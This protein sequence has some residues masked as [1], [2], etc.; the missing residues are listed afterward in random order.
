MPSTV[1]L[2]AYNIAYPSISLRIRAEVR[3]QSDPDVI[4]RSEI[5][6]NVG[7]PARIW[8]FAGLEKTNYIFELNTIDEDN[9]KVTQLAFFYV[10]PGQIDGTLVRAQEQIKV[11]VTPGLVSGTSGFVFDGSNS[12]ASTLT[13][14]LQGNFVGS[15]RS[16]RFTLAGVPVEGDQVNVDLN[17]DLNDVDGVHSYNVSS[18]VESGWT[19]E[20]LINDLYDKILDLNPNT[21]LYTDDDDNDGVRM[22][23]FSV[24]N[25]NVTVVQQASFKKPDWRGWDIG[26]SE[27]SGTNFLIKDQEFT[28]DKVTGEFAF[29]IPDFVF[30]PE[31]VYHVI[32]DAKVEE[33]GGVPF[34]IDF[35]VRL[36]TEDELLSVEDFGKKIIAEPEMYLELELPDISTV[37]SGRKMYIE[38][39]GSNIC[40]K[41]FSNTDTIVHKTGAVY[42]CGGESISIYKFLRAPGVFEYRVCDKDGYFNE[43]GQPVH[44]ELAV[45]SL[46]N[47]LEFNGQNA[48]TRRNARLYNEFVLLLDS[49]QLVDYDSWTTGNNKY[50]FSRANSAIPANDFKFRIPDR[51]GTFEKGATELIRPSVYTQNSVGKHRHFI[52]ILKTGNPTG[53]QTPSA[54]NFLFTSKDNGQTNAYIFSAGAGEANVCLTSE[55]GGTVTQPDNVTYF[56]YVKC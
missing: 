44:N 35:D 8:N 1:V 29:L 17:F 54:I 10:V 39:S 14:P 9:N 41:V 56:K 47:L 43:V 19:L 48:D 20:D 55:S 2:N 12:G 3:K 52:A 34:F 49:D 5:D 21:F 22:L 6:A 36:I 37:P 32:F 50:K 26:I 11:D 27:I 18:T 24:G 51:R 31:Q 40:V 33:S 45:S 16:F 23:G 46:I 53:Q 25:G 42:I 15:T 13:C 28:W 38:A 30:Q 7:H 4:Y